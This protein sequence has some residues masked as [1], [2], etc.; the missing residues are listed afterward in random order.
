[1]IKLIFMLLTEV[2]RKDPNPYRPLSW[3]L[4]MRINH[5][6]LSLKGRYPRLYNAAIQALRHTV[7]R[8]YGHAWSEWETVK[9]G[10]FGR[11]R[12]CKVCLMNHNRKSGEDSFCDTHR[13]GGWVRLSPDEVRL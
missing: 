6:N 12:G 13:G 3:R 1:M 2:F 10:N 9:Y 5:I 8:L 4:G 11:S 7:C